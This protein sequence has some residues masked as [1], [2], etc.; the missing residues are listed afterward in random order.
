MS[1]YPTREPEF[2]GSAEAYGVAAPDSFVFSIEPGSFLDEYLRTG[3][4]ENRLGDPE[5][6]RLYEQMIE[7]KNPI[8]G[9]SVDPNKLD[10]REYRAPNAPVHPGEFLERDKFLRGPF[11]PLT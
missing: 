2:L 4:K 6:Q 9:F 10:L 5:Q 7:E 1:F 3:L 8:P 11:S